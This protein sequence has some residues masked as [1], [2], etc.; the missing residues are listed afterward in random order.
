[1][2][3]VVGIQFK[4]ASKLYYFSPNDTKLQ[5]GEYVIVE[6]VRGMELG[7]VVIPNRQMEDEDV[8]YE[9]KP[10]VRKAY[11]NDLKNFEKNEE[12]AK[13]GFE[14]FKR[15]VSM[16]NLPM[17]PLYAE[18]T[19]DGSKI[20]FY[21]TA[22]ERVDFRELLKILTPNFKLRVEL[23]QIGAR[24]AAAIIGGLGM[25]GRV[26][27]CKS[28]LNDFD[29]V[30]IKMAKEQNMSLNTYKISGQCGKLMCCIGFE[31]ELYK[32]LRRELP[33][34]GEMVK[35]PKC[36]C[37]KVIETDYIKKIVTVNEGDNNIPAKYKVEDIQRVIEKDPSKE[38]V[39]LV[40]KDEVNESTPEETSEAPKEQYK[41]IYKPF[42]TKKNNNNNK[43]PR[44]KK[45]K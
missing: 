8:P 10:I 15:C 18:Y 13:E 26:V 1:M 16:L 24:E 12:L 14:V 39:E 20:I 11:N 22:D 4:N 9:L 25:C 7:K 3:E 41:K 32:E 43:K 2:K 45:K 35:T 30:T 33:N 5:L 19:I 44:N 36:E 37:C 38:E 28:C 27:C 17:K 6:T 23:R 42:N 34:P 31:H 29:F 21:Y 40:V